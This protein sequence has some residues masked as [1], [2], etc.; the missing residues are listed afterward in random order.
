MLYNSSE[1]NLG[2]FTVIPW[3]YFLFLETLTNLPSGPRRKI[4]FPVS[5]KDGRSPYL[6]THHTSPRSPS[7]PSPTPNIHHTPHGT[8][9][10]YSFMIKSAGG[11]AGQGGNLEHFH[12]HTDT[13][14]GCHGSEMDECYKKPCTCSGLSSDMS[15]GIKAFLPSAQPSILEVQRNTSQP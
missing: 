2:T 8:L 1:T 5:R 4:L 11:K 10:W 15:T 13:S 7:S 12:F 6:C 9:F 3:L 14:P